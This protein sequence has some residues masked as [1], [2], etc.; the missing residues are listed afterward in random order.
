MTTSGLLLR[1]QV[2][3]V[4]KPCWYPHN[5]VTVKKPILVSFLQQQVDKKD[6]HAGGHLLMC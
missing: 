2:V 1:N 3:S 6:F 5:D 4:E